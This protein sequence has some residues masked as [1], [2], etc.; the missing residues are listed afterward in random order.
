MYV[1]DIPTNWSL[2]SWNA[3]SSGQGIAMSPDGKELYTVHSG[4]DRNPGLAVIDPKDGGFVADISVL[5][6]PRGIRSSADG[7]IALVTHLG[8]NSISIVDLKTRM[9]TVS[10]Q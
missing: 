7:R 3:P 4:G 10:L 2:A 1:I 8:I 6:L 5:D 9:T